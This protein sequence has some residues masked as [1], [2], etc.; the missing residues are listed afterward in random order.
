MFI[1]WLLTLFLF[2]P[3][4]H[5]ISP[6]FSLPSV[7]S[8][9]VGDYA[10]GAASH[11]YMSTAQTPFLVQNTPIH[12]GSSET[13]RYSGKKYILLRERRRNEI[14]MRLKKAHFVFVLFSLF[15]MRTKYVS[16]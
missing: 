1:T 3:Q 2:L 13:P 15:C 11:D 12:Y 16:V 4:F 9:Q 7:F 6:H 10:S 8:L 14:R 5:F